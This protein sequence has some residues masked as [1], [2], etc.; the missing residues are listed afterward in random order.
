MF[1]EISDLCS[2]ANAHTNTIF[3]NFNTS[4]HVTIDLKKFFR[5]KKLALQNENKTSRAK[6]EN[7]IEIPLATDGPKPCRFPH[8]YRGKTELMTFQKRS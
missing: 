7:Q 6:T 2:K 4:D 3:S 1:L 8:C 5:E